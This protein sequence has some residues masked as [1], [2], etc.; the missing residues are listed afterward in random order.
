MLKRKIFR[1][2]LIAFIW[3][4]GGIG[5]CVEGDNS[6]QL[7]AVSDRA[8]EAISHFP[9]KMYAFIWRNWNLVD[10][11]QMSKVLETKPA[12]IVQIAKMMG[13]P[14]YV[15][16]TW[17]IQQ[18]YITLLRRNWH[19]LPYS[20]LMTLTNLSDSELAQKLREDDFLYVKLGNVKPVCDAVHYS[21]PTKADIRKLARIA[22]VVHTDFGSTVNKPEVPRFAFINDLTHVDPEVNSQDNQ[23][24]RF[25]LRYIYSYFGLFGDPLFDNDPNLYPDG[26]LQKLSRMGI[27]GVWLHVVLRD[28]A[29][30]GEAFPEFG[31]GHEQR[32]LHLR[33]LVDRA[34]K[35]GIG[36][37]LYM[38]EPRAMPKAFFKNRPDMQGVSEGDY[39]AMCVSNPIVH[40]WLTDALAYLFKEVPSLGG[41]FSITGSEN[42]TT[43]VSHGQFASCER[44]SKK[45]DTELI[46]DVNSAMEEGVHRSAPNAKVIVWDWGWR[47]HQ[48]APDIISQLPNNIWLMSVS[49]WALPLQ[50]GGISTQVGEYSISAVGPGPRAKTHWEAAQKKGLKTAAKMQLNNSWEIASVPFNP[51]MDLVAQ[52]CWNLASSGVNGLMLSW[53]LGGYPSMNLLMSKMFD[54]DPLPSVDE[55]LDEMARNYYGEKGKA[56]ARKGWTR[57]SNAFKE[58]PYNGSVLY[59]A[60]TQIGPANLLR[61]K[62]SGYTATMV[63]IP[64]DDLK[65]WCGPYPADVFINQLQKVADGY[66]EGASMLQKA[67]T[68][69][70]NKHLCEVQQQA[71]Y[72]ETIGLIY[73]SAANQSRFIL[74]RDEWLDAKTSTVRKQELRNSMMKIVLKEITLA[75]KLYVLTKEDSCIGFEASNHYW[76]V[77]DDLIEKVISCHY[78]LDELKSDHLN[79]MKNKI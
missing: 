34:K 4:M 37:Y 50:R 64:Y 66:T 52:H 49:E 73:Q 30:G 19:I 2:I 69:A 78:I 17:S 68:L 10:I 47:G 45:T 25:E 65:T 35:Y 72:A 28:M 12:N 29:P 5:I 44:C 74:L 40:K 51:A 9:N 36:V 77:P 79:I 23:K 58:F 55:A 22:Q 21:E 27:N 11:T 24:S 75:K 18:I 7:P 46:A 59:F 57:L 20:Q 61:L 54:R 32:L 56:F 53:S 76:F 26:L 70:P 14:Q 67:V 6:T 39:S 41:I 13:L 8:A 1:C 33:E 62:P 31:K 15:K 71:R 16:P 43:C 48:I 42:L 63:G 38:N 3:M 60:P